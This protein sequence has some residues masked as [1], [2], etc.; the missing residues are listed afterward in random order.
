MTVLQPELPQLRR[1]L[2][3]CGRERLELLLSLQEADMKGKG[4]G[5]HENSSR[6]SC[7]RALLTQLEQE[8]G[9][10]TLKSLAVNGNDLMELGYQGREIGQKLNHLLEEVLDGTLPNEKN[11]LIQ[12]AKK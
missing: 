2:S 11:A 12:A 9:R 10:L 5:E 6:Y 1:S 4:T 8:E 7:I 3:R